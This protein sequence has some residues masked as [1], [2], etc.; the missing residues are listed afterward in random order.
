M[1]TDPNKHV[2]VLMLENHSFD[3][4]LG[5]LKAFYPTLEGVDPA[6]PF[7][8]KDKAGTVYSQQPISQLSGLIPNPSIVK[9]DPHHELNDTLAQIDKNNNSGFVINYEVSYP[10]SSAAELQRIMSYFDYKSLPAIHQLAREFVV[11]DHWFS[12]LQ[13]PTWPN[14]LFALSGTSKGRAKM[15]TGLFDL[16]LHNYDQETIFDFLNNAPLEA[17]QG[18][19]KRWRVYV[20]DFPLSL[21]LTHQRW[22]W[23]VANYEPMSSFKADCRGD[24]NDFPAFTFIEPQYLA[25]NQN[26]DHAPHDPMLAQRLIADVFNAVRGNEALWKSTLLVIVYDEHGGFCDHVVPPGCVPPDDADDEFTFDQLG[27]RVPAVLVSP[28]LESGV[29]STVFDH[30]SLLRYLCDKWGLPFVDHNKRIAEAKPILTAASFLPA[31][32]DDSTKQI[33]YSTWPSIATTPPP[34]DT[35]A[36]NEN[37]NSLIAFSEYLETLTA[38]DPYMKLQ[39]TRDMMNGV[40]NQ[41]EIAQDRAERFIV[42]A[43]VQAALLTM[44][45]RSAPI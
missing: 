27:L 2:V 6:K 41:M 15:P 34:S 32:R 16:N 33:D 42:Q 13:G 7:Q 17:F 12:S 18:L 35:T 1:T 29:C 26:D 45:N 28:W 30:T 8:N 11:C 20:G 24:S 37:Q 43:K 40:R 19:T 25:P 23:N 44:P 39:R 14:R 22:P 31:A 38:G 21:L 10:K 5:C 9:N 3:E 36:L 4:M